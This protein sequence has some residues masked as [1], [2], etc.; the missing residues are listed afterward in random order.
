[1]TEQVFEDPGGANFDTFGAS[2]AISRDGTV[3]VVGAPYAP[4]DDIGFVPG[5]G[6]VYV[7]HGPGLATVTTL[8]ASDGADGDSFGFSV[9]CSADGSVVVVG[10]VAAGSGNGQVY[11]YSG[12]G[13]AT[14]KILTASDA[15]N[16][17]YGNSVAC[18]DDGSIVAVGAPFHSTNQGEA[19]VYSGA[20]WATEQIIVGA[21]VGA[22][23][24]YGWTVALSADGS[25][26]AV[27]ALGFGT[28]GGTG[29]VYVFHGPGYVTESILSPSDGETSDGF[30]TSVALSGDGLT[31]ATGAPYH[32]PYGQAYVYT[33]PVGSE[34]SDETKIGPAT[35]TGGP[36]FG[37]ALTLSTDGSAL[38][39]G[40]PYFMMGIVVACYGPNWGTQQRVYEINGATS[41][42][43]YGYALSAGDNPNQVLVGASS[44]PDNNSI[45]RA[46]LEEIA[47]VF[48]V[49]RRFYEAPPWRFIATRLDCS[50]LTFL[51][52]R[53]FN[54]SATMTLNQPL[55][56][57]ADVPSA[58]PEINTL[59]TDGDPFVA[60]N[61]RLV[62]GFQRVGAS[63]EPPWVLRLAVVL[64]QPNDEV[65][66]QSDTAITHLTGFDPWMV[67]NSRPVLTDSGL[68]PGRNG[69]VVD[70][71]KTAD[72]VI[73]ELLVNAIAG[74]PP[75]APTGPD[76]C[77]IDYTSGTIETLDPIGDVGRF[78]Q[79][80]TVGEA[81]TQ[82]VQA[83][84]GDIVLTP[85]YDPINRPGI[86][87]ELNIYKLAGQV[88]P[89]AIFS[90]NMAGRSLLGLNRLEDGAAMANVVQMFAGQSGAPVARPSS[91]SAL[92]SI[93]K[94]GPYWR[95]EDAVGQANSLAGVAL[96]AAAVLALENQGKKTVTMTPSSEFGPILF[97]EY[98]LGDQV[99]VYA[100]KAFR[101][102]IN[103]VLTS[104]GWTNL[105][106]IYGI[107]IEIPD[108]APTIV[109]DLLMASPFEDSL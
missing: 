95:L 53:A 3:V 73:V 31:L 19:Y 89:A 1:M 20:S 34:W 57:S 63:G 56:W 30:G 90:W 17:N 60:M 18:S 97:E 79:G 64:M 70:V 36:G 33:G 51:D 87:A 68:L 41:A 27:G 10:A 4:Y 8:Q 77:F 88:R 66:P 5:P 37:Q 94:Y 80:M 9:A 11:V 40:V 44:W 74:G 12:P 106:R 38:F 72:Q 104:S 39:V 28:P 86:I 45:G 71:S 82:I 47:Q 81:W 23:Y 35:I 103:P 75:G 2:V 91:A 52:G 24:F 42:D 92:A 43:T 26:V 13:W 7:F 101:K 61:N 78:R 100:T 59:D 96:L 16:A 25:I 98:G 67:L 22:D 29:L 109:G 99:P 105:H 83:G 69:L 21:G 76:Q 84:L 55:V 50:T 15:E 58:D 102:P 14:E 49:T 46:Y 54:R 6:R 85:V 62:F 32:S 93:A 48:P 107:P 65:T 108:D